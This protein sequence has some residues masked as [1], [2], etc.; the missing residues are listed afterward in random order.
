MNSCLQI[1]R[2]DVKRGSKI[3]GGA[4]AE[5][6]AAARESVVELILMERR[7]P[8]VVGMLLR[9]RGAVRVVQMKRSM[10]V[11]T[12]ESERQQQDQAAQGQ[13]SLHATTAKPQK[14]FE[15]LVSMLAQR[16]FKVKSAAARTQRKPGAGLCRRDGSSLKEILS[17][18]LEYSTGSGRRLV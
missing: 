1:G 3:R 7:F 4:A 11:A 13:A 14:E 18:T 5:A 15:T 2:R 6:V 10:G 17:L 16:C 8:V 12:D 9:A